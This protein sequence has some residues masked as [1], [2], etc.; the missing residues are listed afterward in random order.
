[1]V[2][3]TRSIIFLGTPHSGS[4]VFGNSK[5]STTQ[6]L[7]AWAMPSQDI[8]RLVEELQP[9]SDTLRDTSHDF[10]DIANDFEMLS[11]V[12]QKATRLPPP[13]NDQLVSVKA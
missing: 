4:F 10:K 6:K 9:F 3:A 2:A 12:E 13:E 11:F 7:V 8:G 1:M 5:L